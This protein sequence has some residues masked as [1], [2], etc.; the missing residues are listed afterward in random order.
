MV[1]D[2][3]TALK[4]WLSLN[5]LTCHQLAKRLNVSPHTVKKFANGDFKQVSTPI[6]KE[7]SIHTGLTY[8]QL[9][10]PPA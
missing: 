2:I 5:R 4:T 8:E 1:N 10:E 6:L 9:I 3:P 7:I